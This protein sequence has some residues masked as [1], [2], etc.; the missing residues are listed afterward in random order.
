MSK[1]P[2]NTIIRKP[3]DLLRLIGKG[4]DIIVTRRP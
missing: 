3:A 2:V 4:V 1:R